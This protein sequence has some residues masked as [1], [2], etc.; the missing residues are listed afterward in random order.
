VGPVVSHLALYSWLEACTYRD[1][2]VLKDV[3]H[4]QGRRGLFEQSLESERG[5]KQAPWI[6]L[7]EILHNLAEV[8]EENPFVKF[9][10]V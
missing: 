10:N 6:T 9:V 8:R 5:S 1:T 3:F 2:R 4:T 7:I